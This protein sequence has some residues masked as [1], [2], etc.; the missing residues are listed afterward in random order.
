M[1]QIFTNV[2]NLYLYTNNLVERSPL[3]RELNRLL[4]RKMIVQRCMK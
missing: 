3:Y 4:E 1:L 2:I